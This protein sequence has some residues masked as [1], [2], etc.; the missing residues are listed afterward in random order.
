MN[1]LFSYDYCELFSSGN[2]FQKNFF[3]FF[4]KIKVLK[5]K[6]FVRN[7]TR[8]REILGNFYLNETFS[9]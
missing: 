2:I 6:N 7:C 4:R 1:L 3:F 9:P 8:A 5:A